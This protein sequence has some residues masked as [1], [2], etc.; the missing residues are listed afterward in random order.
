MRIYSKEFLSIMVI[1][2]LYI[3]NIG[4]F[5]EQSLSFNTEKTDS[6]E[7]VTIIT[8]V[9]GA[10]K[11]IIID[12]LRAALSGDDI[13]RNIVANPDDFLI[14]LT[15][16]YDGSVH[17][18]STGSMSAGLIRSVDY[19]ALG[20][21]MC[22]G[23]K[24]PEPVHNWVID[25]WSTALPQ[26]TFK[27][28]NI[29]SIDHEKAFAGVMRGRK[30]NVELVNFICQSDYLR[31]SEMP[32]EKEL[33]E[34]LYQ[35][36]KRIIDLC[37]DN[38]EFKYVQRTGLTPIIQQNGHLLS[39]D[40]LSAGNIFLIEHLLSLMSKLYSVSVLN[41][42]APSEIMNI[43]GLLLIDEIENHLHPK[44]QKKILGIIR[45]L[46]PNLQ[47]ILTTHSPFIVAAVR[48]AKIYTCHSQDGYSTIEDETDYYDHLSVE[49]VL[50]S[51]VFD[52]SPFNNEI[53]ELIQK[54]KQLVASGDIQGAKQ[55]ANQLY[56]IN[57]E[58]FAYLGAT[59]L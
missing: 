33:G 51:G 30:S 50:L 32:E 7:P 13:G 6:Q 11:S 27:I 3:K 4:P 8:G 1:E 16:R 55:I 31:S 29:S 37:L 19:N 48:G 43:P 9:N 24:L 35:N 56:A 59:D 22:Y 40:K 52:V 45:Q 58:Y 41:K 28:K 12:A 42:R 25:F 17:E 49:E 38:G 5:R 47:I 46:F 36:I 26:D 21:F 39:L 53:S 20:H 54:R 44:W 2:H 34:V 57:P 18:Q 15:M 14:K 23:Y 10:G